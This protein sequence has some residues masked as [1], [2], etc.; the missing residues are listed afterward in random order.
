MACFSTRIEFNK[1]RIRR[2]HVLN[3][4]IFLSIFCLSRTWDSFYTS[5]HLYFETTSRK[6]HIFTTENLMKGVQENEY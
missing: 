1:T 4:S 2:V 3:L 5:P 6:E